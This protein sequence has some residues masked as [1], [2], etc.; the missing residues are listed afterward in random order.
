MSGLVLWNYTQ[1]NNASKDFEFWHSTSPWWKIPNPVIVGF[2]GNGTTFNKE[3]LGYLE[4][5][6]KAVTP[7]SLYE[8][9]LSLRLKK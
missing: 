2:R 7:G 5:L 4:S 3:Q 9:Q 1:T 6:D 8:A